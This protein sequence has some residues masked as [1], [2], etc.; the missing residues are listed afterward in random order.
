MLSYNYASNNT[1]LDPIPSTF[2]G[3]RM[4]SAGSISTVPLPYIESPLGC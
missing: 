4:P 3:M 2:A 1:A